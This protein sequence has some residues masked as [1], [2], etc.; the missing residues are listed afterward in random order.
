MLLNMTLFDKD[1]VRANVVPGR[2]LE[3]LVIFFNKLSTSKRSCYFAVDYVYGILGVL[4]FDIPRQENPDV[5]W[6]HFIAYLDHIVHQTYQGVDM[7]LHD[8]SS[9]HVSE[10]ARQFSLTEAK[11]LGQVFDTLLEVNIDCPCM[12]CSVI[13]YRILNA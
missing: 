4:G 3:L 13:K 2:H 6:K 7:S 12:D 11:N 8:N 1:P 10:K 9:I 5:A